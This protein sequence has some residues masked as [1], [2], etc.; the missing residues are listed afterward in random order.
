MVE[1]ENLQKQRDVYV[2]NLFW[3]GLKIAAFFAIPAVGAALLGKY[4]DATYMDGGRLWTVL[5]LVFAFVLSWTI[6]IMQFSK[7]NKKIQSI[8][9]RICEL[10][11]SQENNA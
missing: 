7:I 1:L 4:L 8:E 10:K 2:H 9:S 3:L 5:C 11:K 6:T